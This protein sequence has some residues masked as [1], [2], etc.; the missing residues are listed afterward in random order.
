[1]KRYAKPFDE[2]WFTRSLKSIK[3]GDW[4]LIWSS[5][6]RHELF[7]LAADPGETTNLMEREPERGRKMETELQA[8]LAGLKPLPAGGERRGDDA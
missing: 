3:Q 5:D 4:K 1:M 7:D 6:G 8:F 2:R